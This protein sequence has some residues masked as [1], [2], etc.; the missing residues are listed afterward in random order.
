[1]IDTSG[2]TYRGAARIRAYRESV[3]IGRSAYREYQGYRMGEAWPAM[4]SERKIHFISVDITFL[5]RCTC[6][7]AGIGGYVLT[8]SRTHVHPAHK[9]QPPRR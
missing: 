1:L 7:G 4:L 8:L 2:V 9:S 5:G 3:R 6:V